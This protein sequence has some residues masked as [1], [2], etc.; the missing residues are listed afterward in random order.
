MRQ[1]RWMDL[2]KDYDCKIIHHPGRRNVVADTLSR[3]KSAM[4]A[5][6]MAS[7]WKL[8]EAMQSLRF[9]YYGE[10]TYLAQI[11]VLSDLFMK[12]WEVCSADQELTKNLSK[13][14]S[15]EFLNFRISNDELFRFRNRIWVHVAVRTDVLKAVHASK[16]TIHIGR[17]KMYRNLKRQYWWPEMKNDIVNYV[18]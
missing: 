4:L 5:Q 9:S 3:N 16:L 18:F 2:Q 8:V 7:N 13:F 15:D 1:R 11:R 6:T 12:I 14:S 17:T 10:S